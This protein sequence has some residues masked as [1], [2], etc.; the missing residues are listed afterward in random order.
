MPLKPQGKNRHV[1]QKPTTSLS[2]EPKR[3]DIFFPERLQSEQAYDRAIYTFTEMM[4]DS[5]NVGLACDDLIAGRPYVLEI[6]LSGT[7]S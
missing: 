7:F 2:Q 4:L 1:A 6:A 3:M 5:R